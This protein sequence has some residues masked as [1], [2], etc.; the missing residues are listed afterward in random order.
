MATASRSHT[1]AAAALLFGLLVAVGSCSDDD[2]NDTP[3]EPAPAPD[4]TGAVAGSVATQGGAGVAGAG[5]ALTRSGES[6]QDRTT[7][8]SGSFSFTD[9][10]VGA[11]TLTLTPPA[12]FEVPAGED[13]SAQVMVMENQTSTVDFVLAE[14]ETPEPDASILATVEA[15]G[16][17]HEGATVRLFEAGAMSA[18]ESATTDA[19]GEALFDVVAGDYDVELVVPSGFQLVAGEDERRAVTAES[20]GQA[21]VAFTLESEPQSTVQEVSATSSLTF[22]PAAVT[23]PVG[24]TVRWTNDSGIFHTVTPDGHSE[25]EEA[26][27]PDG[28]VFTHTF[29]TPGTYP[30]YCSPH[31][32]QGMTGVITVE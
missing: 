27:L 17:A 15:D 24:T 1:A 16:V 22:S 26:A 3:T 29:D 8:A 23:I 14:I 11:W 32:A 2:D 25:W 31:L 7:D 19:S 21:M 12:G 18:L 13:A 4:P 5:L 9:V 20:G 10:A 30:Y 28:S 6:P